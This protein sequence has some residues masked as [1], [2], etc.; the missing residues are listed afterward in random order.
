MVSCPCMRPRTYVMNTKAASADPSPPLRLHRLH[1][2]HLADTS[3]LIVAIVSC[4]FFLPLI[5]FFVC[6]SFLMDTWP[7]SAIT[8][9]SHIATSTWWPMTSTTGRNAYHGLAHERCWICFNF[10]SASRKCFCAKRV[11]KKLFIRTF[12]E[13]CF[14]KIEPHSAQ[15][16]RRRGAQRSQPSLPVSISLS[17][18]LSP[19]CCIIQISRGFLL[20]R[21]PS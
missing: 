19:C 2:L 1:A 17:L 7:P 18:H 16:R 14:Q 8:T 20:K 15:T 13:N 3:H 4:V 9:W 6:F 11:C 12:P 21:F 10:W 5:S